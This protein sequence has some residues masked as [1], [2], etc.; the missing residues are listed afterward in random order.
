[1]VI[2]TEQ[3]T[4]EITVC[5]VGAWGGPLTVNDGITNPLER[6]HYA[7]TTRADDIYDTLGTATAPTISLVEIPGKKSFT[8]RQRANDPKFAIKV[9][10]SRIGRWSQCVTEA[11]PPEEAEPG[12]E[13]PKSDKSLEKLTKS[14]HDLLRQLNVRP[15]PLTLDSKAGITSAPAYLAFWLIRQ[16]KKRRGGVTR[17]IPV[18]VLID[19]T[20]HDIRACAPGTKWAP[21]SQA[22]HDISAVHMLSN[23]KRSS[24]EIT[25]FINQVFNG[26]V[27][28]Y[29]D[30]LLL[31]CAQNL[32]WGWPFLNN[33]QLKPDTIQ[34]G[35]SNEPISNYPGLRH[36][37]V[38]TGERDESAES[39][40]VNDNT[41][42]HS[43][44]Y[45]LSSDRIFFSTG[46]KPISARKAVKGASK[47]LPR[48]KDGE[49]LNPSTKTM[50]W[51]HRAL[52]YTIA[53]IQPGDDPEDW[54]A[55]TH[56]LRQATAHYDSAVSLPWPLAIASKLAEYVMPVELI[57]EISENDDD[58]TNI[59]GIE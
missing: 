13:P 37:R 30:L 1:V 17:Q 34:F 40:A 43:G 39:F 57:E 23:Q 55:L 22:Q 52:E 4:F 59:T 16:N 12:S 41:E 54:A 14:W 33:S 10:L 28:L 48:W 20:G 49:L 18:A 32:R 45:W 38:R 2:E 51:N 35:D 7:V 6:L 26:V 21:L 47:I 56:Q 46:D 31:T 9:G 3:L 27:N 11:V 19:P 24:E 50:V 25:R 15:H 36:V 5:Q 42:G 53:G 29:P 8:G 44:A 58:S